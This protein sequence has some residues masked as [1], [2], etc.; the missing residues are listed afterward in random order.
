CPAKRSARLIGTVA[1][2]G[3]GRALRSDDVFGPSRLGTAGQFVHL[4]TV[5][6]L[7][8]DQ[9]VRDLVEDVTMSTKDLRCPFVGLLQEARHLLI[10]DGLRGLGVLAGADFLGSEVHRPAPTESD[11]PDPRA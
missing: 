11:R 7:S 8:F 5:D 2:G 6:L 4:R 10:D 1:G 3:G 9:A